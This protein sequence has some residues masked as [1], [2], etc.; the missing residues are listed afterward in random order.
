MED[1][2]QDIVEVG[3]FTGEFAGRTALAHLRS[4][5]IESHMLTDD[6]GGAFPSLSMLSGGVRIVVRA[7]DAQEASRLLQRFDEDLS[8]DELSSESVD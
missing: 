1:H 5:G 8:S 3:R 6:A 7:E 2:N 4:E